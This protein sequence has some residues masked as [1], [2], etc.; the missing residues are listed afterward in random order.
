MF[1][2]VL[3]A[4]SLAAL[5]SSSAFGQANVVAAVEP[6]LRTAYGSE[7]RTF[8]FALINSGDADATNCGSSVLDDGFFVWNFFEIQLNNGVLSGAGP[9][10]QPFDIPAGE[11]RYMVRSVNA[12]GAPGSLLS[13]SSPI[14]CDNTAVDVRLRL[15]RPTIA[16]FA[17]PS[18]DIIATT[19]TLSGDQVIR[20]G[21]DGSA[22]R[23]AVAAINIGVGDGTG[24]DPSEASVTVRPEFTYH[25]TNQNSDAVTGVPIELDICQTNPAT[26]QCLAPFASE[27]TT[28]IGDQAVT[29][30][31]RVRDSTSTGVRF[32]PADIRVGVVFED[33]NGSWLGLTTAALE[34]PWADSR[35]ATAEDFAGVYRVTL[36]ST[37]AAPG[38]NVPPAELDPGMLYVLPDGR[39]FTWWEALTDNA[40]R[41]GYWQF[42]QG[43]LLVGDDC[44]Q[45][46]I[47]ASVELTGVATQSGVIAGGFGPFSARISGNAG[48]GSF[49]EG[50]LQVTSIPE[51]DADFGFKQQFGIRTQFLD[52][53]RN[54]LLSN[55]TG[56]Y[57]INDGLGFSRPFSGDSSHI[58]IADDGTISGRIGSIADIGDCEFSGT[59]AIPA[60][61]DFPP[62][63]EVTLS[64]CGTYNGETVEII[65][66]PHTRRGGGIVLTLT[67]PVRGLAGFAN[68]V[69]VVE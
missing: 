59:I 38:P 50:Q 51:D 67:E 55:Y 15:S 33:S 19:A 41:R 69:R 39:V 5:G 54:Q 61:G 25:S 6:V 56:T 60:S 27:I 34:T 14:T 8:L 7:S 66:T 13:P 64:N 18:A 29:F 47:C 1:K 68:A 24:T 28:L 20:I 37:N 57:T 11:T 43:Q 42:M 10:N 16:Y 26:G 35:N 9:V 44:G 32:N 48:L 31:F 36:R 22:T 49:I 40:S 63:G 4:A 62:T 52:L 45:E 17:G 12:A 2:R 3:L 46:R 58:V 53:N 21:T 23:A 30:S 65:V